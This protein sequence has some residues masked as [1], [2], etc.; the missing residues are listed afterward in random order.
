MS[1][2]SEPRTRT[3]VQV[4]RAVDVDRETVVK[5]DLT[6]VRSPA[7]ADLVIDPGLVDQA[8]DE[9][10]RAGYDAGFE[11]GLAEAAE[12]G[13]ARDQARAAQLQSVVAQLN[14]ATMGLRQR[15]GVAMATIEMEI[16]RAALSIAEE[17]VGHELRHTPDRA[18][19]AI[20]HALQF[21]PKEGVV[22]ASLNPDDLATIGDPETIAPGRALTIVA[23]PSLSPGD[24]VVEAAGCRVDVGIGGALDRIRALLAPTGEAV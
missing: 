15:D 10:F 22:T 8:V 5:A 11:R 21:A 17:L 18:R 4:L 16:A 2:S 3:R 23:D 13:A 19:D 12:A 9:G 14:E 6:T 20:A 24:C 1:W 7:A